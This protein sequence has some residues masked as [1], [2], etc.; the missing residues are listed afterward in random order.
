M[1]TLSL[2]SA[3]KQQLL[4]T[5]RTTTATEGRYPGHQREYIGIW[6][7]VWCVPSSSIHIHPLLLIHLSIHACQQAR[8]LR[9]HVL[10]DKER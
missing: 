8:E 6:A 3:T 2:R 5:D 7:K 1:L 4:G 9:K 10:F